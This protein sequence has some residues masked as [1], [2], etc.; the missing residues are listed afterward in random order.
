[1]QKVFLLLKWLLS[2]P[3]ITLGI[4]YIFRLILFPIDESFIWG[5]I[6]LAIYLVITILVQLLSK[7]QTW[8]IIWVI[9]FIPIASLASF[10]FFW[11]T[12]YSEEHGANNNTLI[13]IIGTLLLAIFPI[14]KI[15]KE[16][17]GKTSIL[18]ILVFITTLPVLGLNILYYVNYFPTVVDKAEFKNFKYYIVS[19]YNMDYHPYF[20]FY[21]CEKW[22]LHCKNLYGSYIWERTL[23]IFIDKANN[24]VSIMQGEPLS[25]F[26]YTDS[27]NSRWY[28]G[29]SEQLKN[30]IYQ[31]AVNSIS[32]PCESQSC[33]IYTYT[34]YECKT[35][36][37]FCNPTS[38]RYTISDEIFMY[39][40]VN[41]ATNEINLYESYD[42]TLIFTYGEHPRCYVEG[43]EILEEPK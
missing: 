40:E 35:D 24:E 25:R 39:L 26:I 16:L 42:D 22:S 21:K 9:A 27:Q 32:E 41:K 36:Y 34:L 10:Y 18:R 37:T 30:H 31:I 19:L 29:Y 8:S 20:S 13:L 14:F 1:M 23:H 5:I 28:E 2:F 7:S 38:M 6:L 12:I 11:F 17:S 4:F 33:D 15:V 3:I 43:C